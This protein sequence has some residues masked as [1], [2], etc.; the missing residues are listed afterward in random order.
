MKEATE[1][2]GVNVKKLTTLSLS[3]ALSMILSFVE[4]QI[5]AFVAVPGIKVGLSNIV[6]VFLIYKLGWRAAGAVS[7]VRVFLSSVLFGSSVSLI[8]SLSGAVFSFVIMLIM[9]RMSL[10]SELGVSVGGGIFHNIAQIMTAMLIMEN[11]K[12][13]MYLPALLI[14][15]TIAGAV[16]GIIAAILV[17]KLDR[18]L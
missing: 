9:K 5:P 2:I 11:G 12:I 6:T 15:G 7:L 17:K 4:S 1:V 16:V 14:S 10:F 8:Y 3:V 18:I 13:A